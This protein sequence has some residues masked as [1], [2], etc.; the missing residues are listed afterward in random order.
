MPPLPRGM[1]A[2]LL[3]AVA[4][5]AHAQ[6]PSPEQRLEGFDAYMERTLKDWNVAG[7]AVGVVEGA[8][9]GPSGERWGRSRRVQ[10]GGLS[11]RRCPPASSPPP[12]VPRRARARA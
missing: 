2:L 10:S 11:P 1:G 3:L 12:P 7:V 9:T 5:P 4:A 6:Q 8:A